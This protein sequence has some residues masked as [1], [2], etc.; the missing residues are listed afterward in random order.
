MGGSRVYSEGMTNTETATLNPRHAE[1]L[2]SVDSR[3]EIEASRDVPFQTLKAMER[4]G[5]VT[6]RTRVQ[7]AIHTRREVYRVARVTDAGR[8]A[9]AT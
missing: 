9:L 3:G 1:I 6:I 4:R 5:L 2:R 7:D 8:A